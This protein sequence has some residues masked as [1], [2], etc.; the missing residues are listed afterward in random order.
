M[1]GFHLFIGFTSKTNKE[2]V[3]LYFSFLCALC[4]Y[5]VDFMSGKISVVWYLLPEPAI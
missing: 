3:F 4:V 1:V 2:P 5:V